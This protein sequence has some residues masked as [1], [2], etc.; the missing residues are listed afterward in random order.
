MPRRKVNTPFPCRVTKC[1][2]IIKSPARGALESNKLLNH[3]EAILP[4]GAL[5][6]SFRGLRKHWIYLELSGAISSN[7][8]LSGA[9]ELSAAVC[10]YPI[11]I[12]L[13]LSEPIWSYLDKPTLPPT[14]Q[15]TKPQ[16]H[17]ATPQSHEPK[18]SE[19]RGRD[20]NP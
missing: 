1:K 2:V 6:G 19:V 20:G 8:A 3:A 13:Q 5:D 15:H 9:L 18:T 17:N 12:Y 7:L 10:S 16:N 11:C 14:T 4:N